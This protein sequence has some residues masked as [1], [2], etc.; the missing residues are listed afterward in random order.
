MSSPN[1]G[2][3]DTVLN[4]AELAAVDL[5]L[6]FA[7][8]NERAVRFATEEAA[9]LVTSVTSE[10]EKAIRDI[11]V[12]GQ[13]EGLNVRLQAQEIRRIVGL[14][15]RDARA[16]DRFYSGLL[17]SGTNQSRAGELADRMSARLLRRRAE[18]IARTETIRAANMGNQLSWQA[19]MDN[20][21]LPRSTQKAWIATGDSR[22]CA[23][24][25]VLDGQ[26]ISVSTSFDVQERAASF[27]QEGGSFRVASKVP[28]K[29]PTITQTPPSHPSCR[30]T[31]GLVT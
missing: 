25:A 9:Q 15:D 3:L 10:T 30:C 6:E 18:N 28:L 21:L 12:R 2:V 26:V 7:L 11:V 17:E 19:A 20:G 8:V 29:N 13:R 5:N 23:I 24:C 4:T 14:T 1:A 31:T 27:T 22:T 16:V